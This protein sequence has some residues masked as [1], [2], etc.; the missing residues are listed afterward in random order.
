MNALNGLGV[1]SLAAAF[2]AYVAD[3]IYVLEQ[4]K[5]RKAADR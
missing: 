1:M 5:R 4:E 3:M 2:W